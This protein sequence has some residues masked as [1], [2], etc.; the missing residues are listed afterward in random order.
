MN[1]RTVV[2]T[3]CGNRGPGP[4]RNVALQHLSSP[5][6]LT[7]DSDDTVRPAGVAALMKALR[8][9]PGA[10]WAA[11]RCHKIGW[12]GELLWEGPPDH[13][14]PGRVD[15]NHSFWEAKL[16]TGVIPFI[17]NATLASTSAVRAVGGWPNGV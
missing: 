9:H 15:I 16:T 4:A 12:N 6:L 2:V 8:C 17:C 10:A 14:A 13:F 11:G 3:N 5:W 7:L 1:A